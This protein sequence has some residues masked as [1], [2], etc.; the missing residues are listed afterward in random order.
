SAGNPSLTLSKTNN[1]GNLVLSGQITGNAGTGGLNIQGPGFIVMSNSTDNYT[2]NTTVTAGTL[3]IDAGGALGGSTLILNGGNLN[4][5]AGN[6]VSISN[7]LQINTSSFYTGPGSL[8]LA[9]NGSF[10]NSSILTNSAPSGGSLSLSGNISG[11]G[12]ITQSSAGTLTL[13]GNNTYNGGAILSAGTL[14]VNNNNALGS[15]GTLTLSGGALQTTSAGTNIGNTWSVTGASSIS[16]STNLTLSGNGTLSTLLTNTNTATTTLSGII[17]GSNGVTQNS[18]GT[19][20]LSGANTYT[21]ATTVSAGTLQAGIANSFGNGSD[22]S[23]SSGA[24]LNLNNF[25]Q[26]IGSLAGA[27]NVTLSAALTTG[28]NSDNNSTTYSGVMSGAG[29]LT[30]GGTGTLTLSGANTYTGATTV[31]AGTLTAG[32]ANSFGN[33]SDVSVASGAILNLNSFAQTIGSLAGAGNVTLS[34]ALTTG[35]NSNNNSTTY[36]GVMNGVGSLTKGGTG[37][38]TLSGANTYTGATAVSAGTLQAG[39]ANSFGNGSDVSVASGAILNLNSFAQTIGSLAGAGNVTLS[40]ALTTGGNSD[41]NST[42]YSGV[43]SGVGSLTKG[44]TGTF[45]LSGNNTY[46]GI[47]T[48]SA[49]TLQV[50]AGSTSGSLGTNNVTD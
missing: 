16:G 36:S 15:G 43:M 28:G 39:I 3:R 41:N 12:S 11:S 1:G 33:G 4:V 47:T 25:A 17:S 42:T 38:L 7:A 26:T 44:G 20:L 29:S 48:I 6:S 19:L 35:G 8:T 37:T 13:G 2:G 18:S 34:A 50:G 32:I 22:I 49:G 40:A 27:G 10:S 9:G 24:I 21:G 46:G 30:K 31:S 23:V 45:I 14:V 5:F